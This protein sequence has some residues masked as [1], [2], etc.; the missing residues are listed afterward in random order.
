MSIKPNV[1]KYI[2]KIP[3]FELVQIKSDK[4]D[5]VLIFDIIFRHQC[6]KEWYVVEKPYKRQTLNLNIYFYYN[7]VG[8]FW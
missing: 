3:S 6:W 1:T 8:V 5:E 4:I 2:N 7:Q